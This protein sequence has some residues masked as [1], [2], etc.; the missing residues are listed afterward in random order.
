[1]VIFTNLKYRWL[2][3][4]SITVIY[5]VPFAW[6]SW[7]WSLCPHFTFQLLKSNSSSSFIRNS[8]K[9]E[10]T[11][12]STN[13]WTNKLCWYTQHGWASL[14]AQTVK[15]PPAMR[16]TCDRSRGWEDSLEKGMAT[17]SNILAWR[18]PW[19]EEPGGLQSVGS[20]SRTWLSN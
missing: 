18:I 10:T 9:V 17:H 12:M 14:V 15:N 2:T 5:A 6:N 3:K 7:P 20:Q 8:Q 19:T 16:Q 13:Y 4:L 11:Q 1:M